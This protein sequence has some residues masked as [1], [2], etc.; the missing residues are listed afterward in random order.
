MI[1][2]YTQPTSADGS[3]AS[4]QSIQLAKARQGANTDA[5]AKAKALPALPVSSPSRSVS[6]LHTC[7]GHGILSDHF[8][9]S[10]NTYLH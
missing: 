10:L 1:E 6:Q 5:K 4:L 3:A 7:S 2:E 9:D 8:G